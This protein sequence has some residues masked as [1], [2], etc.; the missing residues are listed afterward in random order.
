M[1]KYGTYD[2][3]QNVETKEIKNIPFAEVQEFEKTAEHKS[4]W[5]KLNTEEDLGEAGQL[6]LHSEKVS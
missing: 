6:R 3:Y 1:E 5:V 2:V 4:V